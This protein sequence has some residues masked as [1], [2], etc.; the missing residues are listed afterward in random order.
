MLEEKRVESERCHGSA[1]DGCWEF[2]LVSRCHVAIYRL[3]KCVKLI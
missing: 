1:R 2:Y 3:I